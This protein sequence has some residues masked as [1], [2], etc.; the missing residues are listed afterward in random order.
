ML[1]SYELIY[2]NC[3]RSIYAQAMYDRT[4]TYSENE[5]SLVPVLVLVLTQM[6]NCVLYSYFCVLLLKP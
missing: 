2:R 4:R 5:Y 6:N 3:V 1:L